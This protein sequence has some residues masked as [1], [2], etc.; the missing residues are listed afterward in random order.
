[1]GVGI[2]WIDQV[3]GRI[4]IMRLGK[5]FKAYGDPYEM[6][7]VAQEQRPEE[8][9]LLG[10]YTTDFTSLVRFRSQVRKVLKNEGFKFVRWKRHRKNG[11]W[12][13]I[14]KEL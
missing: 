13:E 11:Q 5:D 2:E 7:C 3:K 9:Y 10:A 1:M 12:K 8:A 6:A 14:R 4:G